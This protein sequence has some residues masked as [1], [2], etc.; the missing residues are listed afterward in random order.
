MTS[1]RTAILEAS[2]R[3]WP[4]CFQ[5]GLPRHYDAAQALV[6]RTAPSLESMR[7]ATSV[8]SDTVAR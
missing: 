2:S 3:A 5:R 1:S 6:Q 8:E 4:D 7:D